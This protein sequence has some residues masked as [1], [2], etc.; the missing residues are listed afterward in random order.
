M[1]K[2]WGL[3]IVSYGQVEKSMQDI[4]VVRSPTMFTAQRFQKGLNSSGSAISRGGVNTQAGNNI[5]TP[6]TQ[7][8][9]MG[10]LQVANC[11]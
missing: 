6:P 7:M 9:D 5:Y 3:L 8:I 11:S 2:G 4:L 10:L 1:S